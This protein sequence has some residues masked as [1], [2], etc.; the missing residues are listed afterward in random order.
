MSN[1]AIICISRYIWYTCCIKGKIKEE[2]KRNQ[3]TQIK[4]IDLKKKVKK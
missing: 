3:N 4:K 2:K 1:T